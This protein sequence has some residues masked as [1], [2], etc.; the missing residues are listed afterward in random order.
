MEKNKIIYIEGDATNPKGD[1][2]KI[3]AHGCNAQG[4]WGAGFVLAVSARWS[5]PERVYRGLRTMHKLGQVQLVEV[6]EDT[7]VAN[8]ITQH[9]HPTGPDMIPLRYDALT[10]CF[11]ALAND[12]KVKGQEEKVTIHMPRI[13]AGLAGG[14]WERIEKIINETLVNKGIKVVVY[15]LP[16]GSNTI[17]RSFQ[18]NK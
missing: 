18:F 1:G 14:S 12:Y 4:A 13:G 15:D 16:K 3:I 6:E 11:E 2:I 9:L 10:K 8:C 5:K 17:G 7:Y